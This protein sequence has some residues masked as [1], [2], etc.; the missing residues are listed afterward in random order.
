MPRSQ[1]PLCQPRWARVLPPPRRRRAVRRPDDR[2]ATN[3]GL[4]LAH[5][6]APRRRV[7]RRALRQGVGRLL[8]IRRRQRPTK[9]L[10][11]PARRASGAAQHLQCAARSLACTPRPAARAVD[12]AKARGSSVRLV[13]VCGTLVRLLHT[14]CTF[15]TVCRAAL[16]GSGGRDLQ[17]AARFRV[18]RLGQVPCQKAFPQPPHSAGSG[19]R[20]AA[21]SSQDHPAVAEGPHGRGEGAHGQ[22]M[23]HECGTSAAR[24]LPLLGCSSTHAACAPCRPVVHGAVRRSA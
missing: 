12:T 3:R 14:V 4:P 15:F 11:P 2:G 13:S 1:R 6:G 18:R 17:L 22:R 7:R 21:V 9:Q 20:A 16:G 8:P 19:C 5:R 10:P 24:T 23:I